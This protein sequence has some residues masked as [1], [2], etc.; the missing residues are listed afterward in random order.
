M[1]ALFPDPRSW[2]QR[3]GPTR[4]EPEAAGVGGGR[5]QRG[6]GLRLL[7]LAAVEALRLFHSER[8]ARRLL[9]RARAACRAGVRWS[10]PV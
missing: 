2:L 4:L 6:G 9:R 1:V 8:R 7:V 3:G 10:L 5:G